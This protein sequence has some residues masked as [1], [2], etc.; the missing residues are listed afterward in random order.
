[1]ILPRKFALSKDNDY[2]HLAAASGRLRAL[3]DAF[4]EGR[5]PDEY[6]EEQLAHYAASLLA[7]Q[8]ADGSFAACDKPEKLNA[9][10]QTDVHRFVNWAAA[11][12]LCR[13]RSEFPERALGMSG[14]NQAI[15]SVLNTRIAADFSFPESGDAEPVQQLEAILV[16]SSGGVPGLLYS[17]AESAPELL[18]A[19]NTLAADFRRRIRESDTRLPGDIE[20]RGF[21]EMAVSALESS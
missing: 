12:F 16:L 19:I 14:L 15:D 6:G 20:Y 21:F 1:M 5:L 11:A 17:E 10:V 3:L 8:R 4:A 2:E 13:F 7:H 9:D 18:A